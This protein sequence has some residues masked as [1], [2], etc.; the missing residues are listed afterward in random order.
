MAANLT[1]YLLQKKQNLH[2]G[3]YLFFYF[4]AKTA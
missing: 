3:C 1:G 4:L 2:A